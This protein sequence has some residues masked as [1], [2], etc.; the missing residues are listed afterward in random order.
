M[1][2]ELLILALVLATLYFH[3]GFRDWVN[4]IDRTDKRIGTTIILLILVF[5]FVDFSRHTYP[6][7]RWS[8]Y[9][10][11]FEPEEMRWGH[12][13]A[14]LVDGTQV[15]IN[16]TLQ[17]PSLNRNIA[18][19]LEGIVNAA[20]KDQLSENG[21]QVYADLLH[22]IGEQYNRLNPENPAVKL[23]AGLNSYAIENHEV[24]IT[25]EPVS[26]ISIGGQDGSIISHHS[27]VGNQNDSG[28][29]ALLP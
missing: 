16:P 3:P 18:G 14:T 20:R 29:G 23:T 15:S 2:L 17:F 21:K 25:L 22:A 24:N 13:Q 27:P 8:M 12:L 10:E 26:T 7:V 5:H 4:G 6:F 1:I 9:S 11:V 28:E 19:R